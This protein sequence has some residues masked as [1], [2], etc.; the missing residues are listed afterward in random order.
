MDEY[1]GQ[2]TL[3]VQCKVS[4]R[5]NKISLGKKAGPVSQESVHLQ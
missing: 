3:Y 2:G 4:K 1:K 5:V